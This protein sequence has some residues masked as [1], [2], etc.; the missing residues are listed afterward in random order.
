MRVLTW[1]PFL[2]VSS[3]F[4][5]HQ[6]FTMSDFRFLKKILTKM[7]TQI[8]FSSFF[9][10]HL[11]DRWSPAR[12]HGVV[13][14]GLP[15]RCFY[16]HSIRNTSSPATLKQ[17]SSKSVYRQNLHIH[18]LTSVKNIYS[19][20]MCIYLSLY[21]TAEHSRINLSGNQLT[22]ASPN[23]WTNELSLLL[24]QSCPLLESTVLT[25]LGGPQVFTEPSAQITVL[26]L[27][28]SLFYVS[29]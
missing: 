24:S 27:Q 3:V 22:L 12:G 1:L 15:M 9:S 26:E 10:Q 13:G 18:T 19:G 23:L 21:T 6:L 17:Y 11:A 8:P 14:W 25:C 2:I 4:L 20:H 29:N 7:D 5:S 16:P 28:M